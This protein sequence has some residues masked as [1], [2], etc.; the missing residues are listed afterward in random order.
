[1][2]GGAG[3]GKEEENPT[4]SIA[5]YVKRQRSLPALRT[6]CRHSWPERGGPE[7]PYAREPLPYGDS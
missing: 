2:I 7:R 4:G 1:M 3:R 6:G 5:R